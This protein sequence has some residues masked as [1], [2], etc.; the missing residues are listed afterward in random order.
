MATTARD[1]VR[2]ASVLNDDLNT[3]SQDIEEGRDVCRPGGFHPVY[4]SDVYYDKYKVLNKIGHGV[5]ST[6]WLA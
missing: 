6:V 5:Y 3:S 2:P 4:I 1:S